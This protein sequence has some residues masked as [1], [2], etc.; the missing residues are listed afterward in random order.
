MKRILSIVLLC[1]TSSQLLAQTNKKFN[2]TSFLQPVE[3]EAL[4]ASAKAPFA[5]TDISKK[6]IEQNNLGQDLPFL[7]NQVPGVVVNSDAG[8]GV[9]YTGLHIRGTDATRINV[10]LNG[11]PY[12]DAESQI[13]YFVDLPDISSSANSIQVQRGLGTSTNGSGAFG[14]AIN[15]ATNNVNDS[16]Y[17]SL[18]NSF[19]SYNTWKNTFSFGSGIIGKHFTFDGRLSRIS[20]DGYVDRASS[21]LKSAYG[22]LAYVD[23]DQSLRLN[24]FTG[25]EKTYQ[26]WYGIP[27][28]YLDSNRTYN[29]AG[30][31]Q[32][33][34]PYENETDNYTQTHYQLFYNR[35]FNPYWKA[36]WAAFLTKGAGYYE[37][38]R[39]QQSLADYGVADYISGTDTTTQTDLIRRLW[40][41]NSF[42]G[43]IFSV[44]HQKD[45]N[46]LTIGGGWNQYE[47]GHYG[48][49][50]WT[51]VHNAIPAP[52]R[53]YDVRATKKEFSLYTKWSYQWS[54]HWQS[55]LDFQYRSI[56][57]DIKGFEANP[58]LMVKNN[59]HFL[60]PKI[61]LTYTNK[62][63]TAYLSLGT[64]SHEPN[65]D[66]YETGL[67]QQPA[68]EKLTDVELGVEKTGKKYWF[69]VNYYY[70]N[71]TNQLVLTGK[72]NDIGAYT[73][74]NIPTSYRTGIE[75]QG[76]YKPL[77]WL[78][79]S[80]NFSLSAN[81]INQFTE[82]IDD[83]DNGGQ[84]VNHYTKTD[85]S[86][87]P[88]VVAGGSIDFTPAKYFGISLISK[89]VS[90]QYLD[91][92]SNENRVLKAYFV[93][94]LQANYTIKNK[95][96]KSTTLIAQVN[97]LFNKKYE[98][99]G[100]TYSY[101]QGG[102]QTE[103]YYFPMAPTNFMVG[104]NISVN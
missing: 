25:K 50:I 61:G 90:K 44:Q 4:R 91:N 63:W 95:L 101:I 83:Y 48:E 14:G 19:G 60:N 72:I 75:L 21:N 34:H 7:L 1:S 96:F 99:T 52:Y 93:E 13:S 78:Q 102:L 16:F 46:Q 28:S 68:A 65:R 100:Y 88:N 8:N 35:K 82:Y 9:G 6:E 67:T 30:Q 85:I 31:E 104:I 49:V 80:A 2:D 66:D 27:A 94:N 23:G 76:K 39:A 41:N 56:V 64:G 29:A 45:K 59:Y 26:A 47:G 97:N 69:N 62:T 24:I 79:V 37:E 53:W 42:Y 43:S 89:Y 57:Y 70:M 84:V 74:T 18:N 5:K 81:K 12:N 55:F 87:S 58:G 33:K 51:A 20:S 54:A 11:I 22:S 71:Y 3:V 36:N 98:S 10:T 32:P 86:F 15:L 77:D 38:Y 73:R 17:A 103:N 40:L 92:T